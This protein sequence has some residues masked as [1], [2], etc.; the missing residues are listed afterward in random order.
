[1]LKIFEK[2]KKLLFGSLLA[3]AMFQLHAQPVGKTDVVALM[4]EIPAAPQSLNDA[5]QRAYPAGTTPPETMAWYKT[6]TEKMEKAALEIQNLTA[7]FY[8][9][10]PTGIRPVAQPVATASPQQHA[11]MDAATSEL[12]QKMLS[13]PAFAQKF[14]AMSEKEQHAYIAGVMAD[15]G[16]KPAQGT[17]NVNT[18]PVAGTDVEWGTLCSDYS[19]AAMDMSRWEAQ[20]ALE[21]KYQARHDEV[22]AWADQ[23][24]DKLPMISFGEYGHDHDPEQ[25]KAIRKQ[26]L[27]KHREVAEAML[28]EASGFF[29]KYRQQAAQRLFPL[30]DALKSARYGA[31]YDFGVF[32]PTV[33]STQTMM[34]SELDVLLKNEVKVIEECARWEYEWRNFK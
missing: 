29:A 15:K 2:M 16:I 10:Y 21:S 31:N 3:T 24:I 12:A 32:Y 11:S 28:K 18:T 27:E 33:I 19:M 22:N 25:V 6:A 14:M 26:A 23:A 9:K 30:N 1:M 34:V 13:D 17:P 5:F 8:R 20:A 7:D 4:N